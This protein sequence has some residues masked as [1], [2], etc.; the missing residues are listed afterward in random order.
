M[1]MIWHCVEKTKTDNIDFY[2][3]S[4]FL[5]T[6]FEEILPFQWVC[7]TL[8]TLSNYFR[9]KSDQHQYSNKTMIWVKNSRNQVKV[10]HLDKKSILP[11]HVL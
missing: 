11:E 1:L 5:A 4:L 8:W 3:I 6:C 2:R 9:I 7:T 10:D